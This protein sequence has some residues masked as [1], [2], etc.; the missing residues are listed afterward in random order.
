[1]EDQKTGHH[2]VQAKKV[3]LRSHS[4][5]WSVCRIMVQTAGAVV[6]ALLAQ[7]HSRWEA[8]SH[9]SYGRGLWGLSPQERA[10]T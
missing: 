4:P 1:M 10:W 8:E 9:D 7:V 5:F 3:N 2:L 6:Q